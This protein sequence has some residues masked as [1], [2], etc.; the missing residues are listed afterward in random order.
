MHEEGGRLKILLNDFSGH[1]FPVQLSRELA[2][3]GHAVLHTYCASFLTPHGALAKTHDDPGHFDVQAVRLDADFNKYGLVKRWR[4]E[5]AIGEKYAAVAEE[6]N[7]DVILSANM[8]LGAQG[9]LLA[10][11][12]AHRIPFIF[13]L[14]DL[15]GEGAT[16]MLRKRIPIMGAVL[17]RGFALY[18]RRLLSGSTH[19]VT[20]TEDFLPYLPRTVRE[21]RATIIENWAPIE[22]LPV[23]PK[24]NDWSRQHDLADKTC[25][26][27]AGTLGMKHNP[28]LLLELAGAFRQDAQIRVVV[29]S[30]GAGADYLARRKPAL[31]LDNLLLLGF[32]PFEAMP[33]VLASADVLLTILEP[34]AGRFAVPSKVLTY[35]CAHRPLLLAVPAVNLAARIVTQISAGLTAE[36]EDVAEFVA[37]AKRLV[38]DK[39]LRETFAANGRSYAELTFDINHF[40]DRFEQV[41]EQACSKKGAE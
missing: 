6:F 39:S 22:A 29:I 37:G 35:L 3:R 21:H 12:Q 30:E 13:W 31:G 19:V 11:A 25:L 23:L 5:R 14:Q 15:Y 4:Q 8:P 10:H 20:I 26:L 17:G 27:Y 9:K 32:Q 1:P 7:A 36:P 34:D 28:D 24:D 18:E 38:A 41:F 16:R 33:Q 40:T 2:R